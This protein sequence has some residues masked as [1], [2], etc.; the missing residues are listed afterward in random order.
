MKNVDELYKK[1]YNSYKNNYD[2]DDQLNEAKT[3][4]FHYRKFELG[5]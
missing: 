4:E 2:A 5:D 3:K 1:Y